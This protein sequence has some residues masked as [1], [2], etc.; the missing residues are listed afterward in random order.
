M[1]EKHPERSRPLAMREMQVKTPLRLPLTHSE[2][3]RSKPEAT[4]SAGVDA[5]KG[6]R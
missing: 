5:G 1:A 2:W 3:P 4:G 6:E